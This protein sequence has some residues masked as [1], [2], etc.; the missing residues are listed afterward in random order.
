M[1]KRDFENYMAVIHQDIEVE[2]MSLFYY[3]TTVNK[4]FT[5]DPSRVKINKAIISLMIT[6]LKNGFLT[7]PNLEEYI[8]STENKLYQEENKMM[9]TIKFPTH[10]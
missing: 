3:L 5:M 7:E 6:K 1:Y 9:K 2:N 10:L 4:I 8:F